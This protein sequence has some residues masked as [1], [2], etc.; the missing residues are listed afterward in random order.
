MQEE[1]NERWFGNL[2]PTTED[3]CKNFMRLTAI[4]PVR[5]VIDQGRLVV[6]MGK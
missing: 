2:H 4:G 5:S 6:G 3:N 1:I